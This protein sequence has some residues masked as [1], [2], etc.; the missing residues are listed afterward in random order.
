[1]N[2]TTTIADVF[3]GIEDP[4]AEPLTLH[5]FAPEEALTALPDFGDLIEL[6]L[7]R[8]GPAAVQ[9]WGDFDFADFR[10][11]HASII[12]GSFESAEPDPTMRLVGQAFVDAAA[13]NAKGLRISEVTPLLYERQLKEHFRKIR[14]EGLIGLASG[15]TPFRDRGHIPMRILELPFRH[16]GTAV[17]RTIHVLAK[18]DS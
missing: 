18:E 14:D 6:W 9:D 10:G 1:M 17:V 13:A 5:R 11:W 16:G 7:A 3:G 4:D 8:R 2:D 15:R 12:L